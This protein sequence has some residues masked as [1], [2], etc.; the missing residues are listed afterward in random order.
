MDEARITALHNRSDADLMNER[1]D[2]VAMVQ[3]EQALIDAIDDELSMRWREEISMRLTR[4]NKHHGEITVDHPTDKSL[5]IHGELRR[6]VRWDQDKLRQ[7]ANRAFISKSD[8]GLGLVGEASFNVLFKIAFS[9]NEHAYA[10]LTDPTV[11]AL[12]D[13]ARSVKYTPPRIAITE[14]EQS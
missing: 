4:I 6:T 5:R 11:K 10:A 9:I 3:A 8:G 14:K 1:A 7:L 12:L 13:S 2:H